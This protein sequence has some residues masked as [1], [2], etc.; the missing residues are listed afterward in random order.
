MWSGWGQ[1][2]NLWAKPGVKC[3][4]INDKREVIRIPGHPPFQ[5]D[6]I[7][8]VEGEIYTVRLVEWFESPY[9]EIVKSFLGMHVVEIDRE[10]SGLTGDIV[11]FRI[12]RFRPLTDTGAKT[13]VALSAKPRS[14]K[15]ELVD[16]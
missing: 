8:P 9:P 15:R 2:M 7:F 4:C 13:E 16:A 3:V 11:P 6:D 10:P 12:E 1:P 14:R 5:P